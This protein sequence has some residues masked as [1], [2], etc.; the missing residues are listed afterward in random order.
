MNIV[1][2]L[3]MLITRRIESGQSV[4][5]QYEALTSNNDSKGTMR[6]LPQ[7]T[8]KNIFVGQIKKKI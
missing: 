1:L 5:D 8:L 3:Q 2:H 6:F 4:K 7:L